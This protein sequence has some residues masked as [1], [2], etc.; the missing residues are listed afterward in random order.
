MQLISNDKFISVEHRVKP[1][2]IG[3]RISV[4]CFLFPSKININILY[5]P[6][7]E[8]LS[9]NSLPK[10]RETSYYEYIHRY[11]AKGLDGV[12][13]LPHFKY[14]PALY[15][16]KKNNNNKDFSCFILCSGKF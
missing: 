15:K 10:Y 4:A 8:L 9:D 7:K 3:P 11:A 13:T 1:G 2:L 14:I 16:V 12:K 5:E 6:L